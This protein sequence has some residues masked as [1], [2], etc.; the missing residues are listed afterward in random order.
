MLGSILGSPYLGQLPC[1]TKVTATFLEDPITTG[2]IR[3]LR[4]FI[5]ASEVA[6]IIGS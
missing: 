5:A 4:G 1:S 2:A 3:E 6:T